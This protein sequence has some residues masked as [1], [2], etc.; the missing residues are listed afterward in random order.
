MSKVN[1]PSPFRAAPC[2]PQP[3]CCPSASNCHANWRGWREASTKLE[4]TPPHSELRRPQSGDAGALCDGPG[5][6]RLSRVSRPLPSLRITQ[7]SDLPRVADGGPRGRFPRRSTC[8]RCSALVPGA[9]HRCQ[10]RSRRPANLG[11]PT[12]PGSIALRLAIW[13][14]SRFERPRL[15]GISHEIVLSPHSKR[16]YNKISC[17]TFSGTAKFDLH[18]LWSRGT[19]CQGIDAFV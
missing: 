2:F 18:A 13:E 7:E 10:R 8:A 14:G 6:A 17:A 4:I 5:P 3:H 16:R 1:W 12:R 19:S 11:I 15:V 9:D